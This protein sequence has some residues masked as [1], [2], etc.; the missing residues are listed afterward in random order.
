MFHILVP[1][2]THKQADTSYE[3]RITHIKMFWV[4]FVSVIVWLWNCEW[5]CLIGVG[6]CAGIQ[7]LSLCVLN[8][9]SLPLVPTCPPALPTLSCASAYHPKAWARDLAACQ[10]GLHENRQCCRPWVS[11]LW[12]SMHVLFFL[13]YFFYQKI[14]SSLWPYWCVWLT[15][16]H[17]FVY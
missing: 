14:F 17:K 4:Y 6:A 7:C 2:A 16:T 13:Y 5:E 9:F 1:K 11:E 15:C 10:T 8:F 3:S 12:L